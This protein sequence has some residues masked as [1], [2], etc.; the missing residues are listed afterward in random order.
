MIIDTNDID[1]SIDL[2]RQ[3]AIREKMDILKANEDID[4]A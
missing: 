4:C 3:A 1:S 2:V